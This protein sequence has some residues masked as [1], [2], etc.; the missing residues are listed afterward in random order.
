MESDFKNMDYLKYSKPGTFGLTNMEQ[1]YFIISKNPKRY[2]AWV[3]KL[4]HHIEHIDYCGIPKYRENA[5]KELL[6]SRCEYI[7]KL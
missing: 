3:N 2:K 7:Q 1:A 5:I 4:I 6:K